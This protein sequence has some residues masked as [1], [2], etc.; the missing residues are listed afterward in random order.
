MKDAAIA[1]FCRDADTF[2][3]H[4]AAVLTTLRDTGCL[5]GCTESCAGTGRGRCE[6]AVIHF[7]ETNDHL[8]R[9]LT[10]CAECGDLY[11]RSATMRREQDFLAYLVP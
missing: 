1:V 8:A 3:N 4:A 11:A 2:E 5:P 6:I 9:Y 10:W 7:W